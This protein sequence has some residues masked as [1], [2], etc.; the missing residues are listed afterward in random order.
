MAILTSI[1]K[2]N[3]SFVEE[4]RYEFYETTKFPEKKLVILTCMDTRLLEL[5]HHAMGLR[6]GDAKIIKNAGAVVSHPFGS[7]MRSILVAV[8]ELQA[9]EVCVIGHHECG[10]ASLN[11]SSIL[12]KAKQRGVDDVCLELLQHSGIDLD[13]WMTGFDSVEDSVSHSVNMVRNHPLMPS[14]VPVHGL[15]IDPKTGCLDVVE[16]GYSREDVSLSEMGRIG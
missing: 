12:Q 4:K 8:Y 1:L 6:N 13:T 10:M 3:Q 11:A 15:V 7:V 16:D 2:Q 14:D 5:L 9:E